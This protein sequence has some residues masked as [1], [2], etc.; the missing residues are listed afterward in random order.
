MDDLPFVSMLRICKISG[1]EL[2][3]LNI[4]NI[5]DIRD[6]KRELRDRHSFPVCLQQLLHKGISLDDLTKLELLQD[7]S[8]L[9]DSAP[10]DSLD[11][12]IHLQ[13][14]LST[15]ST[16]A[17]L[18]ETT[19]QKTDPEHG[20]VL[21]SEAIRGRSS[22]AQ[23]NMEDHVRREG[24][25]IDSIKCQQRVAASKSLRFD[26]LEQ[27]G[28]PRPLAA[29]AA[30]SSFALSSHRKLLLDQAADVVPCTEYQILN[31]P[32]NS[33][34]NLAAV[35]RAVSIPFGPPGTPVNARSPAHNRS[36]V[37]AQS[38][39]VVQRE[40]S[41]PTRRSPEGTP[42]HHAR[43]LPANLGVDDKGTG[44][45]AT[46]FGGEQESDMLEKLGD[47]Y[48]D[49]PVA[50]PETARVQ[51]VSLGSYCGPKLSFQKMGRGAETLPFDWIRTRMSGIL[52]FLRS[53]FEGFYDFTTQQR[54]PE[55]GSMMVMFRGYHHSFWHDD[56]TE[57]KMHERYNRRIARLF[58]INSVV[59]RSITSSAVKTDD[60]VRPVLFVRSIVS[61]EEVLQIPE[62]MVELRK[63]FG[64][65]ARL[66]MV[67]ESQRR[68]N[69]PAIVMEEPG[70]YL[71]YLSCDVHT[72]DHP[73]NAMPYAR[74]TQHALDWCIG[75]EPTCEIRRMHTLQDAFAISDP[76]PGGMQGM[77]GLIAF[78]E[79]T[80]ETS[81]AGN[82][83][84]MPMQ[85]VGNASDPG[86]KVM[87]HA[88]T[89][90][91]VAACS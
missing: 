51:L 65:S 24:Q 30:K 58:D 15:A 25:S 34:V 77:G 11:A 35:A 90:N 43:T 42:V 26:P 82:E 40:V 1:Q 16:D 46:R 61:N 28:T 10:P 21:V 39:W 87:F 78:E 22:C 60:W 54:V 63:H 72:K 36:E 37:H 57:P 7:G 88:Q 8:R 6:L 38:M 32:G 4:Q 5:S 9:D 62:L 12:S 74:P 75:R 71:Y 48:K 23:R 19:A 45:M 84:A 83:N 47:K 64:Q 56:P 86:A 29:I 41:S 44:L 18:E 52:R 20:W 66:L 85:D 14:V 49:A 3:T 53:N 79:S 81:P 73:D 91:A 27:L 89:A 70:V 33:H 76:Y 13:L 59:A 68:F 31:A 17:E 80:P 67:L 2:P 50:D 55:T 69:G